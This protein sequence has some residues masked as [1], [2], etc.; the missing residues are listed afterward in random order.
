MSDALIQVAHTFSLLLMDMF[1][2][3]HVVYI[4]ND[5]VLL[6]VYSHLETLFQDFFLVCPLPLLLL[7]RKNC[8]GKYRTYAKVVVTS[9]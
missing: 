9:Y 4:L 7:H 5:E 2:W 1:G 8:R 6:F 3:F